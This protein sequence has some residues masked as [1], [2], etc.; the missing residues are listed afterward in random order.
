MKYIIDLIEDVRESI[1]NDPSYTLHAGLL[2]EDTSDTT[3]LI[4]AGEAVLTHFALDETEEKLIL[5]MRSQANPLTAGELI[6]SLVIA[7]MHTMMFGLSIEV[8]MQYVDMEIVGFGKNE[9]MKQYLLF[10]KI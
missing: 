1:G 9:E 10:I 8:N 2:R 4:Y 3:K 6:P 7:D 5:S